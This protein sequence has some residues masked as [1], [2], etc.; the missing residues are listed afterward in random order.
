MKR[1][2]LQSTKELVG[3]NSLDVCRSSHRSS[4]PAW[5]RLRLSVDLHYGVIFT[6]VNKIET[7]FEGPRENVKFEQGSIFTSTRD[8]PFIK[9]I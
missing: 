1:K 7:M 5:K 4:L 3:L 2:K 6:S 8:L 9:E